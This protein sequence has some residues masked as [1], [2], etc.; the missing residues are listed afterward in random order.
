M[1]VTTPAISGLKTVTD[2]HD[3][4]FIVIKRDASGLLFGNFFGQDDNKHNPP[5]DWCCSEQC[6]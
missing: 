4:Y 5:T 1:Q 2:N 6:Y 3:F